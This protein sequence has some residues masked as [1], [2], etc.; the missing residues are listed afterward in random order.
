MK[1]PTATSPT[2]MQTSPDGAA[3]SRKSAERR[4]SPT[5][6]RVSSKTAAKTLPAS[7]SFDQHPARKD[8]MAAAGRQEDVDHST[9]YSLLCG[10]VA[11]KK[12]ALTDR[13][14]GDFLGATPPA[15]RS[16]I[17]ANFAAMSLWRGRSKSQEPRYNLPQYLRAHDEMASV[18]E[19]RQK[20]G[21]VVMGN[22]R[23]VLQDTAGP[24]I[25]S[26]NTVVRFNDYQLD[27]FTQHVG[28]KTSLWVMSDYTCAKLLSKYPER[29]VPVLIA[30]P[31]RFMGK[32]YY[33]ARR[34]EVEEM[35]AEM[36]P[37]EA[38]QRVSFVAAETAQ[39]LIE[40][41]SF[42][43]RWPSSGLLTLWHFLGEHE[44]LY[45]HGFDFFKEIDGKIHYMEDNH[46]ANHDSAQATAAAAPGPPPESAAPAHHPPHRAPPRVPAACAG[47]AHMRR[48]GRQAAAHILSRPAKPGRPPP[49]AA[50]PPRPR[51]ASQTTLRLKRGGVSRGAARPGARRPPGAY[52][53]ATRAL[54]LVDGAS[55]AALDDSSR[56]S[57]CSRALVTTSPGAR[58][59]AVWAD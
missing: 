25:D 29:T 5:R 17:Q 10:S 31:Y 42:G 7:G 26:F 50:C 51:R 33:H 30:I 36:L 57:A 41:Y 15:A 3:R 58:L 1:S 59:V 4:A 44:P 11:A 40:T 38:L 20:S 22:G 18:L 9:L 21:V 23:S 16:G 52:T 35:L 49:R 46:K 55:A 6:T 43:D 14:V 28:S 2:P 32:P 12:L 48:P 27:G 54:L 34:K 19:A 8:F 37:D 47:A 39:H 56:I 13:M 24:A 45:L 53:G